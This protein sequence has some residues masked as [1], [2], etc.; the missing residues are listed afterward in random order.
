[1]WRAWR[2]QW[3]MTTR[4][5]CLVNNLYP[6]HTSV[7]SVAMNVT[8]YYLAAFPWVKRKVMGHL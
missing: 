3:M 4:N 6:E 1:M 8:L 7:L 2:E 5:V